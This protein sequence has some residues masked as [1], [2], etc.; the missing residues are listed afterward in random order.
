M[1]KGDLGV[2]SACT[3]KGL[4]FILSGAGTMGS[5]HEAYIRDQLAQTDAVW[6]IC[7]WH[8]NQKLMQIGRKKDEV[9]WGPYEEC[10]KGGAI[11]ATAHERDG[12]RALVLSNVPD[13]EF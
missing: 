12:A 6:R 4:F 7:S 5:G 13:G 3:Y 8:K 2:K 1:C 9:G 10:R 11:I